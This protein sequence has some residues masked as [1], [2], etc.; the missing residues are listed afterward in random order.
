MRNIMF[1]RNI[2]TGQKILP[3]KIK[4]VLFAERFMPLAEEGILE[5]IEGEKEFDDEIKLL[6][7][8]G[9]TP[10]QQLLKISDSVNTIFYCGDLIPFASHLRLPYI[11]SFDLEPMKTLVEKE[12]ILK[13]A[14]EEDWILLFEH[15]PYNS[16][17]KI[18]KNKSNY[19]VRKEIEI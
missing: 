13:T 4:E 3:Q 8:D 1:K 7:L 12:R 2:L 16:A 9:H 14:L 17:V 11:M 19:I 18:E 6:T 5:F 15:D 10:A